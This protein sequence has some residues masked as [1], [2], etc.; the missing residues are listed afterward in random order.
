[1]RLWCLLLLVPLPLLAAF[2]ACGDDDDDD[3]GAVATA[4]RADGG[5]E[6]ATVSVTDNQFTPGSITVKAGQPVTWDWN[7]RSS[8]S[9][10]GKFNGQDVKSDVNTGTDRFVFTFTA[11]GTFDYQCGI[12]GASMPGKVIVQ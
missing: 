1:M 4:T 5:G 3:G 10:V 7:S 12:H 9:V 6:A 2:A 11:A 8:H